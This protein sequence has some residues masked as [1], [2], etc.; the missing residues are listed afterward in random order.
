MENCI[1]CK[2]INKEIPSFNIWENK[3]FLAFLEINPVNH[4]HV[5]LIQKIHQDYL[6]DLEESLYSEIFSLA[7]KLSLP[8]R[9]AFNAKKIGIIVEG[10]GISHAHIHLIP[11]NQGNELD[12][13]RAK[14]ETLEI[15][16]GHYERIKREIE[17]YNI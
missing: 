4:G 3:N 17:K 9:N 6:F 14:K 1:F 16:K 5:L 12:R 11:I 2:I 15:L 8:L 10:F 13:G 7:K